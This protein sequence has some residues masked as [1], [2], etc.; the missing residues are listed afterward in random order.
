MRAILERHLASL[1]RSGSIELWHDDRMLVGDRIDGVIDRNLE[2]A[3]VILLLVSSDFL[4]SDYCCRIEAKRAMQRRNAGEAHVIPIILR[5][6]D[7]QDSEFG[8]L[9][10]APRDGKPVSTWRDRDAAFLDVVRSI[11]S[12]LP[13]SNECHA[14]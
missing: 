4:S 14:R 12:Y 10:A 8:Q 11:K 1:R 5:P 6:C 9:L 7:W 3:D 13:H 2:L